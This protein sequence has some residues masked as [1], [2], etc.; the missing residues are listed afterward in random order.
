MRL[1]KLWSTLSLHSE[2]ILDELEETISYAHKYL[3]IAM[4]LQEDMVHIAYLSRCLKVAK[5][6]PV[7]PANL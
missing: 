4:E 7:V 3:P 5:H 6:T 2:A 1:G